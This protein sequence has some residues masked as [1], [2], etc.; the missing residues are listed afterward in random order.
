[1]PHTCLTLHIRQK[2]TELRIAMLCMD[3]E[4]GKRK[5]AA[6]WPLLTIF[7]VRIVFR[8]TLPLQ[9]DCCVCASGY[10][11]TLAFTCS[12][13]S[14]SRR[15]VVLT[16]VIFIFVLAVL[17]AVVGVNYLVATADKE[18]WFFSWWIFSRLHNDR[19]EKFSSS[20]FKIVLVVWQIVTQASAVSSW[21]EYLLLL[22]CCCLFCFV[23][24]HS[25]SVSSQPWC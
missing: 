20:S 7:V 23:I 10:S 13:C 25:F 22:T 3:L 18:S 8:R 16:F 24:S 15:A 12:A 4:F 17:A 19:F 14:G 11:T 5:S 21:Y 2:V 1:M 9:A 6:P